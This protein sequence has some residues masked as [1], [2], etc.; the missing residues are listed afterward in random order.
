MKKAWALANL[1]LRLVHIP[2]CWF[3][4]ATAHLNFWIARQLGL[5]NTV[6]LERVGSGPL[7]YRTFGTQCLWC[8]AT[9]EG[10]SSVPLVPSY[11]RGLVFSASGA[12]LLERVGLQCL[13]CPAT[14]EGWSSVHLVPS[15]WRGLVF[16]ASGAQLLERVGL[17]GLWCPATGEGW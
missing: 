7:E 15:Y 11:W 16:S 14:G 5:W 17:Q 4:R 10:W 1:S 9:G 8:P 3:C 6:P 2:F 13:W 12:Q